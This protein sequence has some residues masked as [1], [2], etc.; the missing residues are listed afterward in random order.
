[1]KI[2]IV[3]Y[4]AGWNDGIL[5]KFANKLVEELKKIKGVK[6]S[7][8]NRPRR[9][10]DI[11]HHINYAPYTKN[12][13]TKNTLMVTHI[14]K[15]EKLDKLK[16]GMGSADMGICMSDDTKKQ[17]IKWGLPKKKLTTVLPAHDQTPRRHQIV[18]IL[19]NVYPDGC[20]REEMFIKLV[21]TLD[22]KQWA[23]RIM[24][25][26]WHDI[27]VPLIAKGLEVDYF[28]EFNAENHK[29]IIES[30]DYC[31]YFG[32]D[33]GSMGILDAVNAG[34]KTIA[35]PVGFNLDAGI[36][37]PFHNQEELNE[38]FAKLSKNRV[39]YWSWEK[40]ADEHL[41]IWRKLI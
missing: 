13:D 20:K 16:K 24:G 30:S 41:K 4:E 15:G 19:T 3:N 28:A 9:D 12:S 38:I 8:S 14:W 5:S 22:P 23:F 6:V 7:I 27:L 11:N 17:L 34:L 33:E 32:E 26:G 21:R 1:M 10:V 39:K 2:H 40:Y 18:A 25:T 31:L 29:R 35:P 37:Y 36:D